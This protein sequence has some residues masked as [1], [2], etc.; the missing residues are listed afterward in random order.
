MEIEKEE[1]DKDWW[2]SQA[3]FTKN[4]WVVLHSRQLPAESAGMW[5]GHVISQSDSMDSD[6][7][8][9]ET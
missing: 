9:I 3:I 7:S 8:E 4:Y 2:G 1:L 5:Y 6:W